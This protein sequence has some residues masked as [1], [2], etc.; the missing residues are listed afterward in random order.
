MQW[1]TATT[2]ITIKY[3]TSGWNTYFMVLSDS[4]VAL[5]PGVKHVLG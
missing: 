2:T 4:N 1:I 5:V 3:S